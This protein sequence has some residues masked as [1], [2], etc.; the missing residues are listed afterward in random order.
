[1]ALVLIDWGDIEERRQVA[2]FHYPGIEHRRMREFCR[3]FDSAIA[4]PIPY[5]V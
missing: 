5:M 2:L 3:A 1:M 4:K